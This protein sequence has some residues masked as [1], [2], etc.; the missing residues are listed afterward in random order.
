MKKLLLIVALALSAN[1]WAD[2]NAWADVKICDINMDREVKNWGEIKAVHREHIKA[3]CE[4]NDILL[5]TK[6]DVD[7]IPRIIADWCRYDRDVHE[8]YHPM[9]ERNNWNLSCVLHDNEPRRFIFFK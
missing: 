4:R 3:N 9:S 2:I 6:T 1:A 8:H 7:A 5:I